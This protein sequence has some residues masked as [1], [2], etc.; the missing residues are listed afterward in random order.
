MERLIPTIAVPVLAAWAAVASHGDAR[1]NP[2]SGGPDELWP[3][4]AGK[5]IQRGLVGRGQGVQVALRRDDAGVAEALLDHLQ[6]RATGQEPGR[7]R[8]AEVMNPQPRKPGR[9]PHRVPHLLAKPVGWD[10]SVSFPG[11]P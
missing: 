11:P 2:C 8:V 10:V 9:L 7:V 6:V 3:T 5:R 4:D 1:A